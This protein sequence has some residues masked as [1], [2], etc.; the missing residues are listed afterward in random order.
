MQTQPDGMRVVRSLYIYVM[1]AIAMVLAAVGV[2]N[3]LLLAIDRGLVAITGDAWIQGGPDWGRERVSLFLPFV[4]IATPIWWLHWRLAQRDW[5]VEDDQNERNTA[6]RNLYLAVML[7]ISLQFWLTSLLTLFPLVIR[8]LTGD[9]FADFERADVVNTAAMLAVAVAIWV[10]HFQI[11]RRDVWQGPI[12]PRGAVLPEAYLYIAAALG[13][14]MAFIGAGLLLGLALDAVLDARS[15]LDWWKDPLSVSLSVTLVGLLVWAVHWGY[16]ERLLARSTWWGKGEDESRLRQLLLG[17]LMVVAAFVVLRG[18]ASGIEELLRY[19]LDVGGASDGRRRAA[20]ILGPLVEALPALPVLVLVFRRML[21]DP[22]RSPG[23]APVVSIR[24]FQGYVLAL[25]G[26][27]FAGVGLAR[28]SGALIRRLADDK[29]PEHVWLGQVAWASGLLVAGLLLWGSQW[30]VIQR[31]LAKDPPSEQASTIRRAYLF[32]VLGS[33]LVALVVGV[34]I[35]IYRVLQQVLDVK[36]SVNMLADMSLPLGVAMVAA[37]V[38]VPHGILLRRDLKA[39]PIRASAVP[40]AEVTLLVTGPMGADFD[41]VIESL[42]MALPEGF[43]I[44]EA[45]PRPLDNLMD[46]DHP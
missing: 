5:R 25:L 16:A 46:A 44:G 10:W 33:G 40:V 8:R 30:L 20:A 6:I 18:V 32:M 28:L 26:L 31:R 13:M 22:Q 2:Y 11:Y 35:T 17:T 14:A 23:S 9:E 37:V 1:N 4:L 45:R 24:R 34:A 15:G 27:A 38:V 29:V 42:R 12:A 19:V 21:A 36:E 41:P 7:V 3:L 39:R 43:S